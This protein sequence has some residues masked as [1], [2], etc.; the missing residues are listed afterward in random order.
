MAPY[1]NIHAVVA[2]LV[3][4]VEIL[5]GKGKPKPPVTTIPVPL[6]D[7]EPVD[8]TKPAPPPQGPPKPQDPP[9]E[10][11]QPGNSPEAEP[12]PKRRR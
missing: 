7:D 1:A 12:K 5:E 2:D 4:R 6:T 9:P 3:R 10:D 8:P 11:P